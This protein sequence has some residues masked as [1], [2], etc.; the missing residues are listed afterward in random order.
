MVD[1]S[2]ALLVMLDVYET[3]LK[4][5]F[6]SNGHIS[7]CLEPRWS[8]LIHPDGTVES[9]GYFKVLTLTFDMQIVKLCQ[10]THN[11][12]ILILSYVQ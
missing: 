2:Q 6:P 4:A 7:T 11:V 3:T 10:R 8:W 9:F 12:D 5:R 1:L